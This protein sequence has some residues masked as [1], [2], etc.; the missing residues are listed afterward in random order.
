MEKHHRGVI[1]QLPFST[2]VVNI[3]AH[4]GTTILTK[5]GP[6]QLADVLKYILFFKNSMQQLPGAFQLAQGLVGLHQSDIFHGNLQLN[7]I[8]WMEP[9]QQSN[10]MLSIFVAS[11]RGTQQPMRFVPVTGP[12]TKALPSQ[13]N[14]KDPYH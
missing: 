3:Y 13:K 11:S 2:H 6:H 8:W 7:N 14:M 9:R 1:E 10:S 12:P 4:C 5:H